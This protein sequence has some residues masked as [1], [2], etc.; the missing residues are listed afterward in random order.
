MDPVVDEK[1]PENK[2]GLSYDVYCQVL[3]N[4]P[5]LSYE[6]CCKVLENYPELV[7]E[8]KQLLKRDEVSQRLIKDLRSD[9][10]N[11]S[12]KLENA[13]KSMQ[14]FKDANTKLKAKTNQQEK[15]IRWLNSDVSR[16]NKGLI[17]SA[18]EHQNI[19][20][21]LK[22]EKA[23]LKIKI[24]TGAKECPEAN[25]HCKEQLA[26]ANKNLKLKTKDNKL[27]QSEVNA[28]KQQIVEVEK[29]SDIELYED[30]SLKMKSL[31]TKL[32]QQEA[33]TCTAGVQSYMDQLS[34]A[35][36]KVITDLKIQ[37][38]LEKDV[39]RIDLK[40]KA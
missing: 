23:D 7:D 6:I 31:E 22:A 18:Q 38:G 16:L 11:L 24:D 33:Y 37:H 8:C 12:E 1:A 15:E 35:S 3:E 21:G 13:K 19:S 29:K 17:Q 26:K 5:G 40:N 34:E 20:R 25:K 4:Y 28:L 39:I 2:E 9:N 27:L 14:E 32:K 36:D 30:L 10:K